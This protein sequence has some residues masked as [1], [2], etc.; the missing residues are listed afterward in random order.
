[1]GPGLGRIVEGGCHRTNK[2]PSAATARTTPRTAS[3]LP[4]LFMSEKK[5]KKV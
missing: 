2:S 1:M 5:E 3:S 4:L